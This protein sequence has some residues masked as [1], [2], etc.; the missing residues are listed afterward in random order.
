MTRFF[1]TSALSLLA[2]SAAFA[3]VPPLL[4]AVVLPSVPAKEDDVPK[5][6]EADDVA[7]LADRIGKNAK[8]VGEK[9]GDQDTGDATRRDQAKLKQDLD[10]LIDL[11]QNSPPPPM[12]NDPSQQPPPPDGGG[13]GGQSNKPMGGGGEGGKSNKPMGGGQSNKPMGGGSG[14]SQP[15]G[16]SP[17]TGSGRERPMQPMPEK[18][19]TG[20]QPMPMGAKPDEKGQPMGGS[21]MGPQGGN[22]PGGSGKATPTLPLA[23]TIAKDFWGHL[24]E[25]PRQ[26]MMQFFREQ[27]NSRYKDLL[28]DYF[29][30]LAEKEKKG[31]Q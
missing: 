9:L 12:S 14:Q 24:P 4:P 22:Q 19:G 31:K 27:Y 1:L 25:Q 10:K 18:G 29:S 15:R 23:E 3:I 17:R 30:T 5:E 13:G 28:P 6:D 2:A 20:E 26:R 8:G 7:K 11:L 21:P 16:G